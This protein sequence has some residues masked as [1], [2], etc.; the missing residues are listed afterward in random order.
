MRLL[1][2]SSSVSLAALLLAALPGC[3]GAGVAGDDDGGPGSGSAAAGGG[4]DAD[5]SSGSQG[6]S[7]LITVGPGGSCSS[8]D[9]S[10]GDSDG[11]TGAAGD[12]DDCDPA[13]GPSAIEVEGNGKDDNCNGI[14]DEVTT[15][16]EGLALTDGDPANAAKALGICTTAAANGYGL[17]EARWV[18]ANGTAT[19][20]SSQVG[21][22]DA[23]GPNVPPLQGQKLLALSSGR[24]RVPGQPDGPLDCEIDDFGFPIP[25]PGSCPGTGAGQAPPGFPQDVPNCEGD[26]AINDDIGLE[27]RLKAPA[28]AT[29]FRYRFRFYSWEFPEWVCTAFN[30]QYVAIVDPAPAGA[31]SGNISFDS[32]TNPVSVNIAFFDACASCQPWAENCQSGCPAAP[33]PC[34]P[35]GPA[36]LSG[37]GF[38]DA[39]TGEAGATSWL[40][41]RAPIQGGQEFTI[42]FAIWDTGDQALDSTAVLDDFQWLGEPGVDTGTGEV[43][44]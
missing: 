2:L 8:D 25:S 18:R 19:T 40:E 36:A 26:T 17:V 21:I 38:D 4:D 22:L 35:D 1:Q 23:F 9:A 27:L 5:G 6:G 41:T 34:C 32:A 43:P 13:V 11:V 10:D 42:R 14:T 7:S 39:A 20:A 3:S 33:N 31:I 12:C 15:C 37:T 28:N 44:N 30:D 16:D 24:A 29:G